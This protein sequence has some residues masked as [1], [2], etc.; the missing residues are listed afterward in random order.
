M[1]DV[2]PELQ[3]RGMDEYNAVRRRHVQRPA[4]VGGFLFRLAIG[5]RKIDGDWRITREHHSVPSADV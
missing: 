3:S 2:S 1:F 5:P 4:G